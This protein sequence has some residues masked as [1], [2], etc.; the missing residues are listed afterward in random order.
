MPI[1]RE[2]FYLAE[3]D[4][5]GLT[6]GEFNEGGDLYLTRGEL[7]DDIADSVWA[8]KGK[9]VYCGECYGKMEEKK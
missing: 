6:F 5:C 3:C 8:K 2:L 9:K 4:G 1:K 7:L